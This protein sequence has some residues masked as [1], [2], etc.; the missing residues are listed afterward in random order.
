VFNT[1]NIL[2]NIFQA[3]TF[4]SHSSD[5]SALAGVSLTWV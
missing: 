1:K 2:N 4:N 5:T 3:Q